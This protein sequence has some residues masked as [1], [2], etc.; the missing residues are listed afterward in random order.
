[1]SDIKGKVF[2]YLGFA[3]KAGKIKAGVNSISTLRGNIPLMIICDSASDN[4]KKEALSL[5]K[6]HGSKLL[7]T[8]EVTVEELINKE[9]CKLVAVIDDSLA[10]AIIELIESVKN[11]R[12]VFL[13]A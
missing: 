1:M 5:S 10:K 4:T 6:K 2:T 11:D 8:K 3:K 12:F 13:E 7:L 9:N